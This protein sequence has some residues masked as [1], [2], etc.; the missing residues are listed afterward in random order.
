MLQSRSGLD[1]DKIAIST[2]PA[3]PTGLGGT[4]LTPVDSKSPTQPNLSYAKTNTG[5]TLMWTKSADN[6]NSAA[7]QYEVLRS[8]GTAEPSA[9][10]MAASP[11]TQFMA[12]G[13]TPGTRYN[14]KVRVIDASGNE[15]FSNVIHITPYPA[16]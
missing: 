10:V 5:F 13:L 2:Q 16:P 4:A 1:V 15:S 9:V 14:F 3:V 6:D 7:L 12:S 11:A 8:T